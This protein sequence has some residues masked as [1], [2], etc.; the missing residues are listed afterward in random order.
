MEEFIKWCFRDTNAGITTII[1]IG[2]I[3]WGIERIIVAI[4]TR[5]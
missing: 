3:I 2:V 1:V 4:K 5:G